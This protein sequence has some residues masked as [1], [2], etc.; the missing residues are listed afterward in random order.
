M[1]ATRYVKA[2]V[3]KIKCGSKKKK[4]IE[5]QLL[6][7]IDMRVQQG[8][9]LEDII[10]QMG[11]VRE[12]ADSFNENISPKEQ[13]RYTRNK[14]LKIV[15]PIVAILA[16]LAYL[17]YW[18]LPKG[19]AIEDS[20]RFDKTQVENAMKETVELLDAGD[21]VSLQRNATE[22]MKDILNAEILESAKRQISDNWGERLQF[23]NI[24]IAELT[25][26]NS[27]YVVGE[28]TVT[29]DNVSVIYRLTY[30]ED[31][32]LTGLYMR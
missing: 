23:G 17:V 13:K 11:T 20:R 7:D 22:Q 12:I 3:R 27:H 24:Y 30:N 4:E 10:S 5:K 15:I 8:E 9:K 31:M 16:I 14:I 2:I 1:T 19:I 26:M 25:Q 21:Y 32:Q 6:Q 28:I 29:Y 18:L